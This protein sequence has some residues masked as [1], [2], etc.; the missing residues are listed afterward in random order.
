VTGEGRDA[1]TVQDV[2]AA[3]TVAPGSVTDPVTLARVLDGL[4]RLPA[5]ADGA[6]T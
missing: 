3:A 1:P 4:R 2:R 5:A 6:A